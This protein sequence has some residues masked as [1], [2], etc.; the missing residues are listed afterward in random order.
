MFVDVIKMEEKGCSNVTLLPIESEQTEYGRS[1]NAFNASWRFVQTA[2]VL[3]N[4]SIIGLRMQHD[5]EGRCFVSTFIGGGTVAAQEDFEWIFDGCAAVETA[6]QNCV[7]GL[8]DIGQRFYTLR[9]DSRESGNAEEQRKRLFD[10]FECDDDRPAA[11]YSNGFALTDRLGG[12]VEIIASSER[13]GK[14]WIIFI[15]PNEMPLRMR[16]MLSSSFEN[17]T[18]IE[19]EP[20]ASLDDIEPLP[21]EM[22]RHGICG[23]LTIHMSRQTTQIEVEQ[24]NEETS[25]DSQSQSEE[26]EKQTGGETPIEDLD[27]SIRSYNCLKR[28]GIQTVEELTQKTEDEMMRVRNLGKKS[29][30][31]VKEKLIELGLGFKSFD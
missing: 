30:K 10:D 11:L 29:L 8:S 17:T 4:D 12:T 1:R 22:L 6:Q 3:P 23:L 15:L 16:T 5:R 25:G 24:E 14:G 28:A 2:T 19:I 9:Y 20:D 26:A 27:L 21:I 13:K 7:F 31:E 18:A